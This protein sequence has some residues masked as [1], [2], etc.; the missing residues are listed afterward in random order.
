MSTYTGV[1]EL[2]KKQSGFLAH[3][4]YNA[5]KDTSHKMSEVKASLPRAS[6][7]LSE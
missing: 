1:N 7:K 6:N 2:S 3:P 5:L 4:V